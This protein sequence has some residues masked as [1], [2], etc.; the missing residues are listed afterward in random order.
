MVLKTLGTLEV[1]ALGLVPYR[2]ALALQES[3]VRE[4]AA[5][6]IGDTL[7][8]LEHPPVLTAGRGSHPDSSAFVW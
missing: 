7:L 3:L 6:A 5:G 2:E 1:R 8:L 4:R